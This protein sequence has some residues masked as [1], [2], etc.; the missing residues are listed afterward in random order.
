MKSIWIQQVFIMYSHQL[1]IANHMNRV[2]INAVV[3]LSHCRK[4]HLDVV[5]YLI[6]KCG[7]SVHTTGQHN[8]TPLHYACE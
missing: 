8:W 6:E 4:G 1:L 2:S 7:V 5:T 3:Y